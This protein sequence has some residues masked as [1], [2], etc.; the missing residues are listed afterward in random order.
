MPFAV[1]NYWISRSVVYKDGELDYQRMDTMRV[2]SSFTD[3]DGQEWF[4][5]GI[6]DA[7]WGTVYYGN[8]GR[9]F[10]MLRDRRQL[11]VPYPAALGRHTLYTGSGE[12]QGWTRLVDQEEFVEVP[13]GKFKCYHYIHF[14]GVPDE[15]HLWYAPGVGLIKSHRV[16]TLQNGHEYDE[17]RELLE[18]VVQ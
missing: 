17:T 4:D 18:Y 1:G 3:D 7:S 9:G 5:V 13:A 2:Y 6:W 16:Y 14:D 8:T 10:E 15:A 11:L 12:E